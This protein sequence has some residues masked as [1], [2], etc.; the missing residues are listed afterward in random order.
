MAAGLFGVTGKTSQNWA[1]GQMPDPG[2][3]RDS[4]ALLRQARPEAL[5][6]ALATNVR[7]RGPSDR[8]RRVARVRASVQNATYPRAPIVI[9]HRA[10]PASAPAIRPS[11]LKKLARENIP[12]KNRSILA[13]SLVSSLVHFG[14]MPGHGWQGARKGVVCLT[15]P[16]LRRIIEGG[17]ID[18]VPRRPPWRFRMSDARWPEEA[19]PA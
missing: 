15:N 10:M 18:R 5:G 9:S 17:G 3:G 12:T 11:P 8:R 19:A 6:R 14:F 7:A 16:S 2:S 13:I 1:L 4:V